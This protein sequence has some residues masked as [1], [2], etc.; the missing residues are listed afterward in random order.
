MTEM[1]ESQ[2]SEE[3]PRVR[4]G[5][6]LWVLWVLAG[7]AGWAVGMYVAPIVGSSGSI[8]EGGATGLAMSGIVAGILQWVVLRRYIARAGRWALM[9]AGASGDWVGLG[10]AYAA[11]TGFGLVRLL[12][13]PAAVALAEGA[14][15]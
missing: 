15:P 1:T 9:A 14:L 6:R 13:Q 11:I 12:R 7:T 2:R 3:Q 5:W 8:I 4:A 10:A